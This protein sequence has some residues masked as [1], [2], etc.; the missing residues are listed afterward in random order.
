MSIYDIEV[1]NIRGERHK[2]EEYRGQVMLIVNT[3]TN[4]G[5]A[6]HF[7]GLQKLYE[8]YGEQG[9]VVLGFPSNQFKQELDNADDIA[10]VCSLD[11]GVTFPMFAPIEVNGANTHPLF[12]HLKN[13][14][15]GLLGSQSI[16]WNFTKFLVNREGRVTRRF[17]P[18]VDPARIEDSIV[19][20]L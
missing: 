13:K 19:N 8:T 7:T 6:R 12:R 1:T 17:A 18:N 3:A 10:Q 15:R 4:C 9:L 5:Y 2:L 20:M 16:K 11:H 14:A